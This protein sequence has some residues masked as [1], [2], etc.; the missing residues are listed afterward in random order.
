MLSDSPMDTLQNLMALDVQCW[1]V[2]TPAQLTEN[3]LDTHKND[4]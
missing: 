2:N 4:L 1:M 3:S